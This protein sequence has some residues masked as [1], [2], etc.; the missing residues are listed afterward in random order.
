MWMASLAL[1]TLWMA[2]A[3]LGL[4]FFGFTHLIGLGAIA[5]ELLRRPAVRT[6]AAAAH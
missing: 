5:L 2:L 3:L 1:L 4:T 6:A